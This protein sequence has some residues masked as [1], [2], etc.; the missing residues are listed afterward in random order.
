MIPHIYITTHQLLT[1]Q[2]L[3]LLL[4]H[5]IISHVNVRSQA[6]YFWR[7][8]SARQSGFK[9]PPQIVDSL[10]NIIVDRWVRSGITNMGQ[11]K[12]DGDELRDGIG[13]LVDAVLVPWISGEI[14][15][16]IRNGIVEEED[17]GE[18]EEEEVTKYT[19]IERQPEEFPY[20]Q[21]PAPPRKVYHSRL[22]LPRTALDRWNAKRK[23]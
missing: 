10:I 23:D 15:E 20:P 19:R 4:A 8:P 17:E 9:V 12:L 21:P 16:E 6:P 1:S 14:T 18:N 22:P 7:H 2:L 11:L 5:G 13:T 3:S